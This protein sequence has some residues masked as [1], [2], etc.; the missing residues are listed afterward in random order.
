VYALRKDGF[1]GDITLALKDAPEGFA[2]Q[3]GYIPAGQDKV[4][5]TVTFPQELDEKPV[6]LAVEGRALVAGRQTTRPVVPADDMLQAFIY[7]HLVPSSA[8]YAA[9]K[10][11]MGRGNK[12]MPQ[13]VNPEPV[14]LVPG[15]SVKA[16]LAMPGR[17]T[18]F[19]SALKL[20]LSEPPEGISV[21]GISR[22]PEGIS[23]SFRTDAKV[24]PGLRGNLILEAFYDGAPP[25]APAGKKVDKIHF[26]LGFLPAIPFRVIGPAAVKNN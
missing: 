20:E 17:G 14:M 5:A 2:L 11:E 16:L 25:F 15:S 7:H 23:I 9:A 4:R 26:P 21:E 24:K 3:G 10:V 6:A 8:L 18:F 22:T 12:P 19:P 1:K 13:L